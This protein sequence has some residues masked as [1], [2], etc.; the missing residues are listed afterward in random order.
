MRVRVWWQSNWNLPLVFLIFL[1]RPQLTVRYHQL[2]SRSESASFHLPCCTAT[3]TPTTPVHE[4]PGSRVIYMN[5]NKLSVTETKLR[6]A[7]RCHGLIERISESIQS[8]KGPTRHRMADRK[9][10]NRFEAL[11]ARERA[12]IAHHTDPMVG[13][14]SSIA[15]GLIIGSLAGVLGGGA[16][17]LVT[18]NLTHAMTTISKGTGVCAIGGATLNVYA[19][20]QKYKHNWSS[21]S[22]S[23]ISQAPGVESIEGK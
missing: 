1:S 3:V 7:V 16:V 9:E 13:I 15:T 2:E 5:H 20:V 14:P 18:R 17:A 23:A 6:G 21:A 4:S 10:H 12:I 19:Y 22:K 11:E 8:R